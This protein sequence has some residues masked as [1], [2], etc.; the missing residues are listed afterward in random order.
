MSNHPKHEDQ[1][2]G[3][4]AQIGSIYSRRRALKLF[5]L[6]GGAAIIGGAA[7][8]AGGAGRPPRSTAHRRPRWRRHEPDW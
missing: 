4:D 5:G 1:P 6:A 8:I 2:D 3:D 7:T